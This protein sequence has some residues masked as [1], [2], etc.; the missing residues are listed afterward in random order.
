MA[1]VEKE[2]LEAANTKFAKDQLKAFVELIERLEEEKKTI[3]DGDRDVYARS[4][5]NGFDVKALRAVIRLRKQ[6]PTRSGTSSSSSWKPTWTRW[7]AGGLEQK[8][9]SRTVG[10]GRRCCERGRACA[11]RLRLLG[12]FGGVD[13]AVDH[14]KVRHAPVHSSNGQGVSRISR[15]TRNSGTRW[16]ISA[17]FQSRPPVC[18]HRRACSRRSARSWSLGARHNRQATTQAVCQ[19][20]GD[21]SCVPQV[22][23]PAEPIDRLAADAAVPGPRENCGSR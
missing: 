22:A 2:Q 14:L 4:K 1:A 11:A 6:E 13:V 12:A 8:K 18:A 16:S 23:M 9:P 17:V 21:L 20:R 3:S 19:R 5:G 15:Q 10:Y 7:D